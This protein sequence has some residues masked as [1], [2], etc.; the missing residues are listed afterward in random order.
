MVNERQ[1]AR[2]AEL[3]EGQ[4]E[5]YGGLVELSHRKRRSLTESDLQDLER[6][7][8][9]EQVLLWR[10]GK[11]DDER[12]NLFLSITA[13][14]GLSADVPLSE[15]AACLPEP[16]RTRYLTISSRLNSVFS[17]LESANR[18]NRDLISASL[19][20]LNSALAVVASFPQRTD[21]YGNGI[22]PP[23]ASMS[24]VVDSRT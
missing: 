17:A 5:L 12:S 1:V 11:L 18:E 2:M 15:V 23:T 3:L 8:Q 24:R 7:I 6:L 22:R 9:A 19:E 13:Q 14:L 21:T 10:A 20:Q 16:G 4:A